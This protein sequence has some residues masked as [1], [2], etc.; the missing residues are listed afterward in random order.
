MRVWGVVEMCLCRARLL[1]KT[2]PSRSAGH[3]QRGGF[4]VQPYLHAL[5]ACPGKCVYQLFIYA[6]IV[7]L[8][9]RND[10]SPFYPERNLEVE[11]FAAV[12]KARDDVSDMFALQYSRLLHHYLLLDVCND[13]M[14]QRARVVF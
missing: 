8:F 6:V 4:G 12:K 2:V 10:F 14:Q 11:V 1:A 13:T 7:D 9:Q 5:H 3:G